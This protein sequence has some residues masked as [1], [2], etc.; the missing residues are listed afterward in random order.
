MGF[1]AETAGLREVLSFLFRSFLFFEQLEVREAEVEHLGHLEE[2]L[3]SVVEGNFQELL[4][5]FYD[6]ELNRLNAQMQY[7]GIFY[8][9]FGRALAL[10]EGSLSKPRAFVEGQTAVFIVFLFNR[11][12][13]LR[14]FEFVLPRG[15]LEDKPT[16][17]GHELKSVHFQ[18]LGDVFGFVDR[19]VVLVV[20]VDCFMDDFHADQD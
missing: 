1:I 2:D 15:M 9:D 13:V 17:L 20:D 10:V 3:D 8:I 18:Q 19:F 11:R 16:D 5:V 12:H 7:L 4:D 14:V 6:E